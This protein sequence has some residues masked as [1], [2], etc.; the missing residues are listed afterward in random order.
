MFTRI[1]M[2]T[3]PTYEIIISV[4]ILVASTFGIGIIAA[5]IYRVGVLLYGTKPNLISIFK[6]VRNA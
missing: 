4:A 5:K 2:S 6:S 3:V 1:A